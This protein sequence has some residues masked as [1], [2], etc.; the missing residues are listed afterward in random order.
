MISSADQGNSQAKVGSLQNPAAKDQSSVLQKFTVT[1]KV[2]TTYIFPD[3][4]KNLGGDRNGS[5]NG[6]SPSDVVA[7]RPR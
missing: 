2:G 5:S 7:V 6:S 1:K 4:R 3:S